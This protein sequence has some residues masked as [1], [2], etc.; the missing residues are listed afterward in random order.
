MELVGVLLKIWKAEYLWR[1]YLV[2]C[3]SMDETPECH[4]ATFIKTD[5]EGAE[6]SAIIGV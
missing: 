3:V 5:I 1:K 6:M 4:N 2:A